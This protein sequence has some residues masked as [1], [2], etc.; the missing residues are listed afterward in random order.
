[1]IVTTVISSMEQLQSTPAMCQAHTA[2]HSHPGV[3]GFPDASLREGMSAHTGTC[4][5][6]PQAQMSLAGCLWTWLEPLLPGHSPPC[7]ILFWHESS[8]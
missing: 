8:F 3:E 1:M 6:H 4:L 7:S 2:R 5:P